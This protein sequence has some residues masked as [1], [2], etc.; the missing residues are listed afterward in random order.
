[1]QLGD[2]KTRYQDLQKSLQAGFLNST[3]AVEGF[4][5][6]RANGID[7]LLR[8]IWQGFNIPEQLSLVAVGGYGR[9]ELHLYS[10]ID[11]L[12]LIP[13]DSHQTYQEEISQFL[14]F[15]WDV[16]LEVGH[17]TRDIKDCERVI[18]DL[19]IVTNML[20]SRLIIGPDRIFDQMKDVIK[21]SDWSSQSF[22]VEK[23]KEQKNRHESFSNTA[24]NLEPN[25]KESPGGLRDIQTVAWVAK[26]YFDV[27]TLF[28]LIASNYLSND[29]Y[30]ILKTSQ[31]FLWRVRFSLHVIASRREDRLAFQ[32][33]KQVAEMLGYTDGDSMAVEHFMKDYYQTV[34]KVSRLNDILLQ[35][36][37]DKILNTQALN[38]RFKI[39]HGYI[40][41]SHDQVFV[42]TPSA[43]IEVFLLIA[44]HNYVRGISAGTLRQMQYNLSLID[45]N[46]HKKRNNNRLFIELLQQNQGVNKA[47]KL[48][49][50]YGVLE[51][52]IPAFGK[53]SG[54][55]QYDLFHAFTVDQHTLFVIRNLRRFFVM[56]Y[57]SEFS[58]CSDVSKNIK[59]PELLLL[60]GLFHDIAKGRGGDHAQL[61]MQDAKEFCKSHHLN[62]SDTKLVVGLVEKHLLMS[63]V[64]Q[65]QDIDDPT[66]IKNFADAMGSFEFLEYLYLLTVADI[67]A[68]KDDLWNDWK[69]SLLRKL[70]NQVKQYLKDDENTLLSNSQRA[71]ENKINVVESAI[72]HGFEMDFV[73]V[74]LND[75][76]KDYYLRYDLDDILWHL[77]LQVN[78]N[79]KEIMV[80]SK[81]SEGGVVDIF[82]LCKD[83][84]GLFFN[85]VGAVEKMGMDIVD[86]KILT[87]KNGHAYNTLSILQN[88]NSNELDFHQAIKEVL[89]APEAGVEKPKQQASHKYFDNKT[90]VKLSENKKWNL[91]QLEIDTLDRVG[92]L[93]NIAYVLYELNI[94]LVNARVSTLGGRVEDVFFIHNA[95]GNPL[96]KEQ[97]LNLKKALSER[98]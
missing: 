42:E 37:E 15:L 20:E 33:Q 3:S 88:D 32:Y 61:G 57:A 68:T 95:Q 35:L 67:R 50:R 6:A 97:Q 38:S 77:S 64:A 56:E 72:A 71:K 34:T 21:L 17:A 73:D 24:Y 66:V 78:K 86:A 46:Y 8:D 51:R 19:S 70:F 49:N 91:S 98:L 41:A 12:I 45:Q 82:V 96:N 81:A 44:K 23:Q 48:M 62:L 89:N 79:L 40:H 7:E 84:K 28:D 53:I 85:L 31:L 47:L 93:S 25:I 75:L 58:L 5:L 59:K 90:H 92:V 9:S 27:N 10:D 54:L 29:E 14:T 2:Y 30:E 76:P 94:S 52:Y 39:S 11:L 55:M 4:V 74:I 87:T 1:M 60:A 26:W 83:F 22:L 63:S 18:D 36:L 65:K 43:F 69:D 16:G 13:N 80:S